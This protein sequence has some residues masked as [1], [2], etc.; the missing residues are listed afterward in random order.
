MYTYHSPLGVI[1]YHVKENHVVSAYFDQN[2]QV[3]DEREEQFKEINDQLAMYFNKKLKVFSLPIRFEKG[4]PFQ[5]EVW[6]ALLEIP[7]GQTR[8]YQD[9]ANT[10]NRPKAVRAVGQACKNNPIG[11]IV[12]CHR[13]IGKDGS[14][15]GYSGTAYI[16]L[17]EKILSF[18]RG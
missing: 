1:I 3:T 5:K 10:I 18:E 4:T 13:V 8:S 15:R 14:M 11:L 17:K 16:G 9:I 7:Y 12:P 6:N 2:S